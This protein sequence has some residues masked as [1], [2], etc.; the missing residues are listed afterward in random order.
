[1]I[2]VYLVDDEPLALFYLGSMLKDLGDF[3]IAGTSTNPLE[4][5]QAISETRPDAVF[6]DID[7]PEMDGLQAAELV[8]DTWPAAD[9]VFITAY[10]QYA[11]DAFELNA[12]DYVLK[13]LQR[14]RME[15]TVAKLKE[16]FKQRPQTA[17]IA[18]APIIRCMN[19]LQYEQREGQRESFR[20]RTLKSE[21]LFCYLLHNRTTV[22]NKETLIDLLFPGTEYKKAMTH[23]YTTIY[24]VRKMFEELHIDI[25]IAKIGAQRG[26]KLDLKQVRIDVDMWQEELL[27]LD[28]V[29]QDNYERHQKAID[30]YAGDY[31]EEQGYLWAESERHR[32]R[33]SWLHHAVRLA[34]FYVDHQMLAAAVS[35]YQRIVQYHPYS[36]EGHLGLIKAYE[37]MGGKLAAEEQYRNYQRFLE[38]V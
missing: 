10:N 32:L 26:Y 7:M 11:V 37:L 34:S 20:W 16:R 21:E 33:L 13:P 23:L 38:E 25:A 6:L 27:Q 31:F 19:M 30:A 36:E 5:I 1:M 2:K 28:R 24:Q 18:E 29:D 15:K 35:L 3:E 9:I 14:T 22:V 17:I 4:A 12:M 8:Q